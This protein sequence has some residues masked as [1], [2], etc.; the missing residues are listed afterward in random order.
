MSATAH[1]PSRPPHYDIF[2]VRA[3]G[4]GIWKALVPEDVT[5]SPIE[6]GERLT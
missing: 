6:S 5:V 3:L 2:G 1:L 4:E